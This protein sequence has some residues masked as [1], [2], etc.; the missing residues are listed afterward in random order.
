VPVAHH[1]G[2]RDRESCEDADPGTAGKPG[3][4]GTDGG[5]G[6]NGYGTPL[7]NLALG[8]V[9]L[10]GTELFTIIAQ[11][12]I[13]GNGGT[14]G[15][16]GTGGAGG[17]GGNSSSTGCACYTNGGAGGDGGP[18]VLAGKAEMPEMAAA[19]TWE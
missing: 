9:Q 18:G 6:Q 4:I 3:G 8:S 14:G 12:G 17:N 11:G 7:A 1:S 15:D 19:S 5:E 2:L 10:G 16:G 13:G